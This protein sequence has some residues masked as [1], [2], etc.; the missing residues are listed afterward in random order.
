MPTRRDFIKTAGCVPAALGLSAADA[1]DLRL[2]YREAAPDWN[3]ALPI[4]NG[5]LGA[6]IFG[7]VAEEHL[8]L[9]ENTLYSEEP[10]RRDLPLDV[11][12]G[13][14]Q[15]IKMLRNG[16]YAEAGE[17]I[18]RHWCGRQQPCYQPLGDL[19]LRFE[20]Q[21]AAA[22]YTRDLDLATAVATVRY[23]QSGVEF[24]RELL[25]SHPDQA[26]VMRLSASAPRSLSFRVA[27]ASVHPT[28]KCAALGADGIALRGQVPGFAL[29]RTLEWVEER[30]EQWKYPEL[31]DK[32]GKRRPFAKP[33][34]YGEEIG[35]RGMRFDAR[36]RAMARDGEVEADAAGLTVRR[37]D[38][39]AP[40][41]DRRDQLQRLR[42]E[43]PRGC[44]RA[45]RGGP[46]AGIEEDLCRAEAGPRGGLPAAVRPRVAQ[47]GRAHGPEPAAHQ[48]AHREV[49]RRRR[50]VARRALLPVRPLPDDRRL[51]PRHAAAQPARALEPARHP[52]VGR[53]LHHQ[54]QHRDELLAGGAGQSVRVPRAAA[55]H[56]SRAG[57]DRRRGGARDVPA[58]R[59]G[60]APQHHALARRAARGQQRHAR[61]LDDGRGV[62]LPAPLGALPVHRRPPLPGGGVSRAEG[63]G[64]VHVGL[65][66]GRR[67][68]PPGH[69]GGQFARAR[70]RLHRRR[71]ASRAR[72]ASPWGPRWTWRSCASCSPTAS[73]PPRSWARRSD[74][75]RSCAASWRSCCPTRWAAAATCRSGPRTSRSG[76]RTTATSRTS[77][78]CIRATRSRRAATPALFEAARR[79]LE[80][81]GDEGTGWS[82]AWKINFWARLEDGDHAYLLVR[83]LLTPAKSGDGATRRRRAAEPVL[84]ASALP[85]RRQLR[86]RGG[87]RRDA[88][89]KPRGRDCTCC[90]RC[91]PPG[92]T[93][94][95]R[96]L[97][98]R[99]GFEVAMAWSAGRLVT[100]EI[101]SKLGNPC[102][103]RYGEK[104][105]ALKIPR[106]QESPAQD[107]RS[108]I[109]PQRPLDG[110]LA[111]Q[112]PREA[113][114]VRADLRLRS[115]GLKTST[116]LAAV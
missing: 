10:G 103:V 67:P 92:P 93:G 108:S 54:H 65:A 104:T 83:N 106:R 41:P 2:W 12:P 9:N 60:H 20:N 4:G 18:S 98:A 69:G 88:A 22:D 70:F 3:E 111:G 105:A 72:P 17:Y 116:A 30:G 39:G 87:H 7:G 11:T 71:T 19:T 115:G 1:G 53:R 13:F 24:T 21:A 33:V 37:R 80:L 94:S 64:G 26:I 16:E 45:G 63:R 110:I 97:R 89:A 5:R 79:T 102:T 58:A 6:M 85:D 91:R 48:R 59:L 86:R 32:D 50:P 100:A 99:G 101:L 14:E 81:R 107:M 112:L 73:G 56:D 42:Q 38:R 95:V 49:R 44:R 52:A 90:P 77:T 51:A 96:G 8:Q 76:R 57:R 68:R 36:L 27:L 47:P 46:G 75:A 23:R 29:R 66:G 15:V 40:H 55:A 61:L 113:A 109:S 82:R 35:G 114:A 25:A 62:A 74:S 84:L 78:R 34:L 43:T 28:A 31:W